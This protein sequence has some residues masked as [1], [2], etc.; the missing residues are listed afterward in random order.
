MISIKE[1][2][3]LNQLIK[4]CLSDE[5][6]LKDK[7]DELEEIIKIVKIFLDH[8][9]FD[10]D[11]SYYTKI[12][13]N[14]SID[15][16]Y[17]FLNQIN[18]NYGNQFLNILREKI[19]SKY[20][21]IFQRKNIKNSYVNG[22]GEVY[23]FYEENM[24]DIY[25][26]MHEVVHK[27]STPKN[28]NSKIKNSLGEIPTI[29][30]EYLLS[31]YLLTNTSYSKEEILV[32]KYNS[33]IHNTYHS[34]LIYIEYVLIKLYQNNDQINEVIINNYLNSLD[35]N[36]LEYQILKELL[37]KVVELL[38]E[39]KCFTFFIRERYVIASLTGIYLKNQI[40]KDLNKINDLFTLI[41]ILGKT[42]LTLKEDVEKL[43]Q[44]D[45]PFNY[46]LSFKITDENTKILKNEYL[47]EVTKLKKRKNP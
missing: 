19:D 29:T 37:K 17:H 44:L 11:K 8:P 24:K 16:S 41:N 36:S 38:L 40:K 25:G 14:T 7:I 3:S 21:V 22:K 12:D 43:N 6:V 35:K 1:I 39:N 10:D 28:Q 42:D 46:D 9:F 45:L 31:D 5:C 30:L 18:K 15:I 27:F 23:I 13:L 33:L 20:S 4:I 34:I 2:K 26:I 47:K 32:Y